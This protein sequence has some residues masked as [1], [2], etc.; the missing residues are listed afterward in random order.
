MGLFSKKSCSI[1]GG[2]IGLLGNRKLEDGNMCK[3]C[4]AKLSPWFSDRRRSTVAEI[5]E[6]LAY[7]EANKEAVA[8]FNATRTFGVNTKLIIDEDAKKFVVTRERDLIKANPDVISFSQVTGC[9]LDINE[10]R[11]EEKRK[12]RE[13]KLV[14]YVP[15]RFTYSYDFDMI[16]RVN[17]PYFDTIRFRLNPLSIDI[18][19]DNPVTADRAPDPQNNLDYREFQDMAKEIKEALTEVRNIAREDAAPKGPVKCPAC[20]AQTVPTASNC[21]EYCGSALN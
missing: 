2:E 9:D 17:T 4:A 15:P 5:E 19:P 13:G 11:S 12:D 3:N 20:G 14:S 6:Q 16:I 10:H 8:A 7:R 21:C 18:N 1:C